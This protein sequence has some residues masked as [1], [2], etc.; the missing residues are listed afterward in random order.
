MSSEEKYGRDMWAKDSIYKLLSDIKD[1]MVQRVKRP[2]M[3]H[4]DK[5]SGLVLFMSGE[6]DVIQSMSSTYLERN[7]ERAKYP[8]YL[9]C[10]LSALNPS[11]Q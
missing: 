7:F 2:V 11:L 4:S 9:W 3:L 6:Q 1:S 8:V 5:D 10:V